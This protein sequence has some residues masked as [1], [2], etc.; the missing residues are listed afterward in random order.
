MLHASRLQLRRIFTQFGDN[1]IPVH[2]YNLPYRHISGN[3]TPNAFVASS[4]LA[5]ANGQS[6]ALAWMERSAVKRQQQVL[7]TCEAQ[8]GYSCLVAKGRSISPCRRFM[9]LG[10]LAEKTRSNIETAMQSW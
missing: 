8:S 9:E 6:S 5:A 3:L 10:P 7:Q 4:R 1:L 2:M